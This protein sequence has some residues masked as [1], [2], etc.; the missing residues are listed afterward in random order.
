MGGGGEIKF[1]QVGDGALLA[2]LD[3][4]F[5]II[6]HNNEKVEPDSETF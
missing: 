3:F 1:G 2:Y 6:S 4:D 5:E